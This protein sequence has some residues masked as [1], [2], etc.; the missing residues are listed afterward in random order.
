MPLALEL[1]LDADAEREVRA[2]WAELER[3]SV[4]SLA[5]HA[6][7]LRPHVTLVVS[8][9]LSG[10]RRAGPALRPLIEHQPVEL[11]GPAFFP[12]EP[13]ILHLAVGPTEGLLAMHRAV[14]QLLD[15]AEVEVWP[16]YQVTAWVPHCT[17]SMGVP[18]DRLGFALTACLTRPLP[19]R[20]VLRD[21]RLTDSETGET[22]T[23]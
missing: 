19:I 22:A 7:P 21:A 1:G 18:L 6:L 20:T 14:V 4:P 13:P 5:T 12:T 2:L 16:H 11:V 15:T 23:L 10:M 8:D 17:L 3:V 9:D